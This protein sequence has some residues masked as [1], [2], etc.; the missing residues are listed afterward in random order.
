M[1]LF[2][3]LLLKIIYIYIMVERQEMPGHIYKENIV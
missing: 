2:I 1:I 3:F